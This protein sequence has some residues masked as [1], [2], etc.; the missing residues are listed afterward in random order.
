[1]DSGPDLL[2]TLVD[3]GFYPYDDKIGGV[4]GNG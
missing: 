2:G 4:A 1:V 3:K